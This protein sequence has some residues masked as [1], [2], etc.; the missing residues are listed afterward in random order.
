MTSTVDTPA[1]AT[2]P[3]PPSGLFTVARAP[4][5]V[6]YALLASGLIVGESLAGV[7]MAAVIG[8]TGNQAPLALVGP[9]FEAGPAVWL[10]LAAFLLA[11]A[12]FCGRVL[13]RPR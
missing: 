12:G 2:R 6:R 7:L 11:C 5:W 3:A 8:A 4:G 13:G 9:G 10:G 1:D